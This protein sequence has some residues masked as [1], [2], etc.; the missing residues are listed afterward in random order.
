VD[1]YV[2]DLEGRASREQSPLLQNQITE[3]K[4][5][6]HKFVQDN[7]IMSKSFLVIVPWRL[8]HL[9][10]A[11]GAASLLPSFGKKK[12]D[13]AEKQKADAE[14]AT[15]FAQN[16]EQLKQ[17]VSQVV[18]GL[19]TTGLD[20]VLLND[21]QLIELFYNFYNP[22]STEKKNITLPEQK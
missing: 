5:F 9:P 6:I 13:T 10:S 17:R 11:S 3:Y 14:K 2:L 8:I 21:E 18:D 15:S 20:V 19:S 1:K 22:E 4:E 16:I 12:D 7:A